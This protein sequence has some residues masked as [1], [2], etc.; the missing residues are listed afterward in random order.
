MTL[1]SRYAE[2]MGL[3]AGKKGV[4]GTG[5]AKPTGTVLTSEVVDLIL[6]EAVVGRASDIHIEPRPSGFKIRLRVDGKLYESL[7]IANAPELNIVPRLKILAGLPTDAG[8]SRKAWDG[9]FSMKI[10]EGSYDFRIATFPTLLGEKVAIRILNK[11]SGLMNLK[12]IGLNP[13]DLLHLERIIQRKSGLFV[14]SGPTSA[15]KTTTLY[16]ML[17]F[18]PAQV[19]NIVTL[20]DPVEYQ[21]DGINQCDVKTKTDGDFASGLKAVL[22]QDPDVILIGEIRDAESAEIAV[23]ASITGHLVL[24]SLHANSAAGI[25]MRLVNMGIEKH[26]VAFALTGAMAQRLVPRVCESCRV[27]HKIDAQGLNRI[28][29]S[30]GIDPKLFVS[31][32][33]SGEGEVHDLTAENEKLPAETVF[34]KGKGCE[35][36]AGTGYRGRIG[37]F[38]I[39][40]FTEE[41]REAILHDANSAEIE[42]IAMAGGYRSLAVDAIQKAKAGLVTLDDIY[43]I[44][45]EKSS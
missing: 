5:S 44:L 20:E 1:K 25:F 26:L 39:I 40:Q 32:Q 12:R 38:E 33:N 37:I 28:C 7:D 9:R 8:S 43:P 6:A 29:I 30:C 34:Y 13:Q 31:A 10:G 42:N 4:W 45:L 16:S 27:P 14:V 35:R 18:L 22:R 21:I 11:D 3:Y 17:R 41:L 15:G 36:C 19:L 23:Q 2:L 24:T